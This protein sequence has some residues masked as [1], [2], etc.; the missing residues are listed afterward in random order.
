MILW[1]IWYVGAFLPYLCLFF[2][3]MILTLCWKSCWERFCFCLLV[4]IFDVMSFSI[5]SWKSWAFSFLKKKKML[6]QHIQVHYIQ[7]SQR[8][9]LSLRWVHNWRNGQI[10]YKYIPSDCNNIIYRNASPFSDALCPTIIRRI[11]PI[12]FKSVTMRQNNITV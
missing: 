1:L 8:I 5:L 6:T 2:L 3:L 10:T 12:W 7:L 4:W 11:H 9:Q